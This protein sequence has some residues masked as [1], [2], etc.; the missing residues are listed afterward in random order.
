[1]PHSLSLPLQKLRLSCPKENLRL[2]L[3]PALE[4]HCTDALLDRLQP[5]EVC[6]AFTSGRL[7]LSRDAGCQINIRICL[8][9]VS[10]GHLSH[11]ETV[12]VLGTSIR[13]AD[14]RR[15]CRHQHPLFH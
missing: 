8:N 10:L 2:W 14:V 1:M 4:L 12:E 5:S 11:R 7:W 9:A 15:S 3:S 6:Q 13:N